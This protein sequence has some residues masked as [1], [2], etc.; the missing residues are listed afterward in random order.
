MYRD[1]GVSQIMYRDYGVSQIIYR[2]YGVSQMIMKSFDLF[3]DIKHCGFFRKR[4]NV[5]C[6]IMQI[7]KF[8]FYPMKSANKTRISKVGV[9]SKAQ[10]AQTF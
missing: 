1:Y 9:K 4:S 5:S 8:Y 7:C 10:T 3:I 2:D 6:C